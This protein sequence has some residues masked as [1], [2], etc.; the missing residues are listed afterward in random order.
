VGGGC[1][2]ALEGRGQF[3]GGV[4]ADPEGDSALFVVC[5]RGDGGVVSNN[6]L[7]VHLLRSGP[8]KVAETGPGEGAEAPT[9]GGEEE[10]PFVVQ[11]H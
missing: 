1:G 10:G 5:E 8:S 11:Q 9:R 2:E 6:G 4:D 7:C 3:A